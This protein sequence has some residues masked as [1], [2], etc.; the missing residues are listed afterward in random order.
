MKMIVIGTR[1]FSFSTISALIVAC[2]ASIDSASA[3][4]KISPRFWSGVSSVRRVHR[5]RSHE[6]MRARLRGL[7]AM[8]GSV[9]LAPKLDRVGETTGVR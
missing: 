1:Y 6:Q 3:S 9:W 7:G 8:S 5:R 4:M 2:A